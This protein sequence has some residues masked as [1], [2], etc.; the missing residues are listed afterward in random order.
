[1]LC[2][3]K[4][5]TLSIHA[6][7]SN[8]IRQYAG[9]RIGRQFKTIVQTN[10]FHVHSLVMDEK[11]KA[12]RVLRD[13]KAAVANVLDMFS[14]ID[15]S[16]IIK[17]HLF[18]HIGSDAVEIG[19][20]ISAMTEL[21][22]Q[23]ALKY[24]L[25]GDGGKP[26]QRIGKEQV[27]RLLGWS[28]PKGDKLT[29]GQVKL[30]PLPRGQKER[31]TFQLKAMSA[32]RAIN[33][34]IYSAVSCWTKCRCIVSESLD[35]CSVDS[36]VIAESAPDKNL[37]ISG[38]ISDILQGKNSVD[39]VLELFQMLSPRD[40]HLGIPVLNI[41]F[42]LNIQYNCHSAKCEATG[43]CLQERRQRPK[44]R[45]K[46]VAYFLGNRGAATDP[47]VTMTDQ[48]IGNAAGSPLPVTVASL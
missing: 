33:F 10:I 9:S 14:R 30:V 35:E 29:H 26:V 11:F 5:P 45:D 40:E 18:V 46:A 6:I 23:E 32:A 22:D 16:K 24:R 39:V 41:K 2:G 36:W 12:W 15:P 48:R 28:N 43:T 34:G 37:T 47:T 7:R 44:D 31:V 27:L 19:A 3:C 4:L 1:M 42:K 21:C 20:L 13:L 38:R 25:T 17:Y 8:Y